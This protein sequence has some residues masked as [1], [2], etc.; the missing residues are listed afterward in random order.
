MQTSASDYFV[1]GCYRCSLGGTSDCKVVTWKLELELIRELVLECGLTEECKWGAPCYTFQG[2][3]VLLV[4]AFKDYAFISF[5][6][7][8]LLADTENLLHSPG[9]NSQSTRLFK[10]NT[11]ASVNELKGTIKAYI[12]ESIEIEKQGLKV[13]LKPL[14]DYEIPEELIHVFSNDAVY[15]NAFDKLT[16]GRKK[17]YLLHF[18]SA[19]QSATRTSRIEKCRDKIFAG[20]GFNEY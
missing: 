20:K 4:G 18:N 15:Q 10:F 8:T 5:V 9:E 6:K 7:G 13:Q 17:S 12:F 16:P 3:N 2:S 19:K 14:E 11:P 1:N